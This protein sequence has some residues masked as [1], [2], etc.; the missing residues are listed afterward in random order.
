MW[1]VRQ[2]T[3]NVFVKNNV[4]QSSTSLGFNF[5]TNNCDENI[6]GA[7]AFVNNEVGNVGSVGV[8]WNINKSE[9]EAVGSVAV[10]HAKIG[11]ILNTYR[12]GQIAYVAK[13]VLIAECQKGLILR[14][15]S[16]LTANDRFTHY[17]QFLQSFIASKLFDDNTLYVD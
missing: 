8:I 9:C 4:G 11:A 17:I 12:V 16:I 7:N 1:S 5:P 15:D 3:D 14:S 6:S 13:H 2:E 10:Y